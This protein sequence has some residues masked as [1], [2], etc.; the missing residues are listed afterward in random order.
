MF[1]NTNFQIVDDVFALMR[2]E[3]MTFAF[4]FNILKFLHNELNYHVWDPAISELTWFRN[5]LRHI[6]DKHAE[7][8]VSQYSSLLKYTS[9]FS[10]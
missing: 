1:N 6:P 7:F 2:S 10:N 3:K 8:D 9:N 5:R 4:G